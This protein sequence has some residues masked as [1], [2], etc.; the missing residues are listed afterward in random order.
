MQT[1]ADKILA[2]YD[3][4]QPP[5]ALPAGVEV[6]LPYHRDDVRQAMLRF[7]QQYYSDTRPR[8]LLLGINPG[9]FGGGV[10]GIPFTDPIR[11][12]DC[13]G[14][15]NTFLRKAEL[16]S[17]F[18]YRMMEALGGPELF[19]KNF[20][21]SS[22]SPLGFIKAGKNLNYYDEKPLLEAV[23]PFAVHCMETQIKW[24]LHKEHA[25]CIGEGTNLKYFNLLNAKHHWYQHIRGLAHPRFIMQYKRKQLDEYVQRYA[26]ALSPF[27]Q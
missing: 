16:S 21:I 24:G 27:M 11:L 23:E 6:L 18:I 14:I 17:M 7:Y 8:T 12:Q 19:Y 26:D 2:F 4:L 15:E 9:R 10:T 1:W 25:F 13:C 3:N 22:V 20:Y 5:R